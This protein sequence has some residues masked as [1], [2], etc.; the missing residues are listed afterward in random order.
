VRSTLKDVKEVAVD[1]DEGGAERL[2]I[3]VED[4]P[5]RRFST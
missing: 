2:S 1:I 5:D 4:D 3:D